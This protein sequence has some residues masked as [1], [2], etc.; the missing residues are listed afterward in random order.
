ML[1]FI[2][3][4]VFQNLE[5][6]FSFKWKYTPFFKCNYQ[7]FVFVEK[8]IRN[9]KTTIL[10][11]TLFWK[12]FFIDVW[13]MYNF[14][15]LPQNETFSA[16]ICLSYIETENKFP[17]PLLRVGESLIFKKYLFYFLHHYYIW[18]PFFFLLRSKFL[19][20]LIFFS[21]FFFI[22]QKQIRRFLFR[23]N[24]YDENS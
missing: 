9:G 22:L 24:L 3:S 12:P 8:Q 16:Y 4:K 1:L 20:Y 17:G 5:L 21:F 19:P 15:P 18:K 11:S 6:K 13:C 7:K 2:V 14:F 10:S 23:K